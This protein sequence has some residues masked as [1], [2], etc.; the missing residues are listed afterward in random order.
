M[1]EPRLR[2]TPY[3]WAKILY[4]R[5]AGDTEIGGFAILDKED[6]LLVIDFHLIKQKCCSVT[7]ELDE[8]DTIKF[9]EE[10]SDLGYE[11]FQYQNCWIHTHP[12][13]CAK[14]SMNDEENFEKNFSHPHWAIFVIVAKG[15]D[16]YCRV[17][18][19]VGPKIDV[20]IDCVI[21]YSTEFDAANFEEWQ[22]EYEDK[23]TKEEIVRIL[24]DGSAFNK[25]H[26]CS[27]LV[28]DNEKDF[29]YE[30]DEIGRSPNKDIGRPLDND[31]WKSMY[32]GYKDRKE[33]AIE[34]HLQ[35]GAIWF[36]IDDEDDI[37]KYDIL[38]ETFYNDAGEEIDEDDDLEKN[39]IRQVKRKAK[40]ELKNG[41]VEVGQKTME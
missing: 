21:D 26:P 3:S 23:V 6:P 41:L 10:M 8:E 13:N 11:P 34:M 38:T 16:K 19:N 37:Y 35:D 12:G 9:A 27:N 20:D 1:P 7:V 32:S 4:M 2:F 28:N 22:K 39:V 24:S 5:D 33:E 31:Y 29:N 17:K 14:P 30:Y 40:A 18:Y 25:F 15:G 36:W